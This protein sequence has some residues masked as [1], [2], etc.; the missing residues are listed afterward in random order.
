MKDSKIEI[1]KTPVCCGIFELMDIKWMV[2]P[3]GTKCMPHIGSNYFDKT[4]YRV[5]NCPSCG[6]YVRDVII[7]K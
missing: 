6:K 3:D 2:F 1:T 7:E 5:N 4:L